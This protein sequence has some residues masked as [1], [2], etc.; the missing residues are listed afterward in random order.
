MLNLVRFI[1][2]GTPPPTFL[3]NNCNNPQ[4]CFIVFMVYLTAISEAQDYIA[5]YSSPP[6]SPRGGTRENIC[7]L[8]FRGNSYPRKHVQDRRKLTSG[9]AIELLLSRYQLPVF[10]KR[11]TE[12]T[13]MFRGM[14]GIF[15]PP[16]FRIVCCTICC[17][18]ADDVLRNFCWK[19]MLNLPP[20]E[21]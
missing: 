19:T 11:R 5:V 2:D 17:R 18:T 10:A 16:Y 9:K 7:I 15:S 13:A 21:W 8:I 3:I 12:I 4:V 20:F 1:K 6:F 14:F